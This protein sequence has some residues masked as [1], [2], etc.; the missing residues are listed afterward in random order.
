MT[1]AISRQ[2]SVCLGHSLS[3]RSF[4]IE[5]SNPQ[6]PAHYATLNDGYNKVSEYIFININ[7]EEA[8]SNPWP[9]SLPLC[10]HHFPLPAGATL[11]LPAAKMSRNQEEEKRTN[12][13]GNWTTSCKKVASSRLLPKHCTMLL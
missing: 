1:H 3:M 10:L 13:G 6:I 7:M 8:T 12:I 4:A 11:N 2:N 9:L 5:G